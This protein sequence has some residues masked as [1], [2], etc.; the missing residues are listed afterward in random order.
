M[1]DYILKKRV[2][3]SLERIQDVL[4]KCICEIVYRP[5]TS[6]YI[7]W[8][9]IGSCIEQHVDMSNKPTVVN[10]ND[11]AIYDVE[12][13]VWRILDVKY[14]NYRAIGWHDYVNKHD[15][16]LKV[17]IPE[18]ETK[19][20]EL[21]QEE[22]RKLWN[23]Q[24][25]IR[26]QYPD[27]EVYLISRTNTEAI[28]KLEEELLGA[29]SKA[30]GLTDIVSE[31]EDVDVETWASRP[32]S[33]L[34]KS[35]NLPGYEEFVSNYFKDLVTIEDKSWKSC[36]KYV[37]ELEYRVLVKFLGISIY[38]FIIKPSDDRVVRESINNWL[39][40]I[41]K[42]KDEAIKTLENDISSTD[43][44]LITQEMLNEVEIVKKLLNQIEPEA[45]TQM[46]KCTDV[47]SVVS[48]WPPLLLPAPAF[49]N[50]SSTTT[51]NKL[52]NIKHDL[53]IMDKQVFDEAEQN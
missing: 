4:S 47:Y 25:L 52:L 19:V 40:Q 12:R 20:D 44:N 38:D 35:F 41:I 9:F 53:V 15:V 33:E 49:V 6:K 16:N 14:I 22:K 26:Q 32:A 1:N 43:E 31:Y 10:T 39:S 45:K 48:T 3:A 7:S 23:E 24:E 11:I 5:T 42:H 50:V 13:K 18:V 51:Q 30:L 21:S 34:T 37:R 2:E 29:P 8:N 28:M 17:L 36:F 27:L 46:S